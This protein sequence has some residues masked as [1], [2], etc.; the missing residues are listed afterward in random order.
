LGEVFQGGFSPGAV[1]S[2]RSRRRLDIKVDLKQQNISR[3]EPATGDF[4][5]DKRT[6]L[7]TTFR[8]KAGLATNHACRLYC[9][10]NI[11]MYNITFNRKYMGSREAARAMVLANMK[12]WEFDPK[13]VTAP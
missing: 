9:N 2:V 13:K 6:D 3:A 11:Y 8:R 10:D 7:F 4:I 1:P 12:S 5:Y